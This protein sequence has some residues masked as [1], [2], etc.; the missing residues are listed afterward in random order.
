MEKAKIEELLKK[1]NLEGKFNWEPETVISDLIMEYL[2]AF[3]IS[4]PP[5]GQMSSAI[6]VPTL[7][8]RVEELNNVVNLFDDIDSVEK[9]SFDNRNRI[10]NL[11]F[12]YRAVG[13]ILNME[14]EEEIFP[15]GFIKLPR[16]H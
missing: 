2:S 4:V 8:K 3:K 13:K 5:N 1:H 15:K 9:Q 10:T 11:V 7:K 12:K 14:L 6:D 16:I